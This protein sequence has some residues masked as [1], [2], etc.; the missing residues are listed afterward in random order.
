MSGRTNRALT[1]TLSPASGRGG[2]S[3]QAQPSK[4]SASQSVASA[5]NPAGAFANSSLIPRTAALAASTHGSVAAQAEGVAPG[6]DRELLGRLTPLPD[7]A[8]EVPWDGPQ[9]L[10][11]DHD[12]HARGH[13]ALVVPSARVLIAGDML[14]D[15]EIPL[16]D[17][18]AADAVGDYRA[19]LDRIEEAA[20]THE[21]AVVI[22]GHGR[23]G[24]AAGLARRFVA[25]RAYLDGLVDG[26]RS[27]DPRLAL[28]AERRG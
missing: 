15:L 9:V 27:A 28:R 16:L 4:G 22:P 1:P 3:H 19:R 23:L 24:D 20:R 25:D 7:G 13:A 12:G 17:V 14:S 26:R 21:V 5:R 6:H 18:D 10:V 11:V 8:T 2:K